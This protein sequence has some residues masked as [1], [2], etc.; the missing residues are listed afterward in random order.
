[1]LMVVLMLVFVAL[2]LL[3]LTVVLPLLRVVPLVPLCMVLLSGLLLL[4]AFKEP[5]PRLESRE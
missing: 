4:C 5:L 1:M 2:V 3:T